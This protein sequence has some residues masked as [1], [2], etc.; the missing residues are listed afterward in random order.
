MHYPWLMLP[1]CVG[2]HL[3]MH[4]VTLYTCSRLNILLPTCSNITLEKQ[5]R[6][7]HAY[8][9]T[10]EMKKS[11]SWMRGRF[12]FPFLPCIRV[13]INGNSSLAWWVQNK[14]DRT[15]FYLFWLILAFAFHVNNNC[16]HSS[17][18]NE[19]Y[20]VTQWVNMFILLFFLS[21]PVLW[22]CYW[23]S[24]GWGVAYHLNFLKFKAHPSDSKFVF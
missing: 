7:S 20:N 10:F 15:H 19:Q 16:P 12:C 24:Q 13:V 23:L 14:F 17:I 21:L 4:E 5:S 2:L 9:K 22:N 18:S 8:S 11:V 1:V 3:L 6:L